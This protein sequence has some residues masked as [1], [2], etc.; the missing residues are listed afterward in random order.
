MSGPGQ[1]LT[2]GCVQGQADW[3]VTW[4][5]QCFELRGDGVCLHKWVCLT[6]YNDLP[7][8]SL[9]VPDSCFKIL[10]LKNGHISDPTSL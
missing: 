7:T 4:C 10:I 8:Y 5:S 2:V 3:G 9:T 1:A 6:R